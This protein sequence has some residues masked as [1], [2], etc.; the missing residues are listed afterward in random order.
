[1]RLIL[2]VNAAVIR[3]ETSL[4]GPYAVLLKVNVSHDANEIVEMFCSKILVKN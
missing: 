4:K 3:F 1:M 2:N